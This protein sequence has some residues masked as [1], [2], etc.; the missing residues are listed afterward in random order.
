MSR[1]RLSKT[2]IL[3]G[4]KK[5]GIVR[6]PSFFDAPVVAQLREEALSL[7]DGRQKVGL[8]AKAVTAEQSPALARVLHD[9]TFK[10]IALGYDR[11]C[12][13]FVD[14]RITHHT[15]PGQR[16]LTDT[17]FDMQRS[18]KFMIYLSDVDKSS[19]A[20][21]YCLGSHRRNTAF[22]SRYLLMGGAPK[23]LPNVAGPAERFVFADME[24]PRGTLLIFDTD[25]FH[26][27]GHLLPGRERLLVRSRTLLSG[28]YDH[29]I[30]KEVAQRNPLRPL[31]ARLAPQGRGATAG[32]ARAQ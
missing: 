30:L 11:N 15:R 31:A 6:L 28:W 8:K 29:P 17:H 24:G 7:L 22:R 13:F 1:V 25:G 21:R 4:L 19:A 10:E 5:N 18:L 2:E 20:F 14:A 16:A 32:K 23:E 9:D 12:R 27:G 3:N 26:T